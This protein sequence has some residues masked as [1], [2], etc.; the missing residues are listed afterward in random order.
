M[1]HLLRV[2]GDYVTL[3]SLV[4]TAV[5]V[6]IERGRWGQGRKALLSRLT[7]MTALLALVGFVGST[8]WFGPLEARTQALGPY[9]DRILSAS[10]RVSLVVE[11]SEQETLTTFHGVFCALG[12]GEMPVILLSTNQFLTRHLEGTRQL[13]TFNAALDVEASSLPASVAE[14]AEAEYAQATV[15]LIPDG[16]RLV[17][18]EIVLTVNGTIQLEIP[19]ESQ[20]ILNGTAVNRSIAGVFAGFPQK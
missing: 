2:A 9:R 14:L 13:L 4:A 6:L 3:V 1:Y 11:A 17:Q 8:L 18:G 5:L 20:T 7:L 15:G 19:F 10:A 16:T 12:K